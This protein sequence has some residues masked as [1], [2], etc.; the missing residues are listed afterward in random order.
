MGKAIRGKNQDYSRNFCFEGRE[1]EQAESVSKE[2]KT[3]G[4]AIEKGKRK[5]RRTTL[6]EGKR[7]GKVPLR[8]WQSRDA[9]CTARSEERRPEKS[10]VPYRTSST[11]GIKEEYLVRRMGAKNWKTKTSTEG[12]PEISYGGT[13][14]NHDT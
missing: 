14:E 1:Y 5:A 6:S 9:E 13:E 12:R 11:R 7:E 3:G 8:R 10:E 2:K 4:E